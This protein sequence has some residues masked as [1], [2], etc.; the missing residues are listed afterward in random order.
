MNNRYSIVFVLTLLASPLSF[1]SS[2]L[3]DIRFVTGASLGYSN[4]AFSEKLDHEISFPS[5]NIPLAMT[6][7]NWQLSANLQ[8]TLKDADI[9]E[10]EDTG[11]AS[12]DDL[13]ITLGY[14]LNKNWTLFGGYKYGNTKIQ[15]TPRDIEEEDQ[16]SVTDERYKQKGP[17]IGISYHWHFEKAGSLSLSVA[18]ADL[19]AT[20]VFSENTDEEEEEELT[21]FDDLTGNLTGDTKGFS[22]SLSWTMPVSS[23]LLFQTRFK[24]NDYQ[25]DINYNDMQFNGIDESFTSLHIG[26]AYV[27]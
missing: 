9:S 15:F 21:E 25:Q 6:L 14:R 12:R 27:F 13:D 19:D 11:K 26:L 5:I 1:A 8:T 7:E 16:L 20:N 17:F 23:N 10:E 4:F 22:Y 24:I 3:Q 2:S 18:F